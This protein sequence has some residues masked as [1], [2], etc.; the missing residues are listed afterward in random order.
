L[1]EIQAMATFTVHTPA[2]AGDALSPEK[3]AFLRDGFSGWA[4]LFGPLWLAWNRAFIAAGVWL[5]LVLLADVAAAELGL[6]EESLFFINLALGLA[7][8]FEGSRVVAWTL[9]RRGYSEES[10]VV[11]SDVTEAEMAFFHNWRP[12]TAPSPGTPA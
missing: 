2:R 3:V 11:G 7:L 5:A 10:V 12:E 9:A 1:K 8:G 4:F 6:G